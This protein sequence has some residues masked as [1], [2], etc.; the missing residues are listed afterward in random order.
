MN[1]FVK[2]TRALLALL[3]AVLLSVQC[4]QEELAGPEK[5]Q[6]SGTVTLTIKNAEPTKTYIDG[7]TGKV[8]WSDGDAQHQR[9]WLSYRH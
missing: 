4:S 3:P 9:I 1:T 5:P 6:M 2:T 8:Y 7:E